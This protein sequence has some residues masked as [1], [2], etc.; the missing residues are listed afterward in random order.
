MTSKEDWSGWGPE[1]WSA[2]VA[3]LQ[4]YVLSLEKQYG[5]TVGVNDIKEKFGG[6][7]FYYGM[8]GGDDLDKADWMLDGAV[9]MAECESERTCQGCGLPAVRRNDG[10][11]ISTLCDVCDDKWKKR[12]EVRN[13]TY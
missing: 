8:S 3:D 4:L 9:H 1:G 7:R 11:W 13:G 2:I 12:H 6:L 5:V 10:Y